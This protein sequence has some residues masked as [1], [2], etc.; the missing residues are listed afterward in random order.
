MLKLVFGVLALCSW[1]ASFFLWKYF[2]AHRTRVAQP[3]NGRVYSLNTHGSVVYLTS[4]EH[5]FVY[6]LIGAGIVF[7][8]LT[9]LLHY[10]GHTNA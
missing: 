9:I 1:F 5:Y 10:L 3:D 2:D 7:F 8:L 6:S 4:G